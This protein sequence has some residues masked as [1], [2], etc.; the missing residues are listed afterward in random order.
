MRHVLNINEIN[1]KEE[2]SMS[3]VEEISKEAKEVELTKN[4][5]SRIINEQ[6]KQGKLGNEITI[7]ME[8]VIN[9]VG[10]SALYKCQVLNSSGYFNEMIN[11]WTGENWNLSFYYE[12]GAYKEGDVLV[13]RYGLQTKKKN[14]HELIY[15]FP[16]NLKKVPVLVELVD[17]HGEKFIEFLKEKFN[18]E[19]VLLGEIYERW[20]KTVEND[21]NEQEQTKEQ[22]FNEIKTLNRDLLEKKTTLKDIKSEI[23]LEKHK[24]NN[25]EKQIYEIRKSLGFIDDK[26]IQDFSEDFYQLSEEEDFFRI[27]QLLL[28]HH[29]GENL[30]YEYDIIKRFITALRTDQLVLLTGPSGT[31]KSSL[32]EQIGEVLYPCKIHHISVQSNWTD[33]QDLLGFFNPLKNTYLPTPFL[34]ALVDARNDKNTLHIICLDEMNLA[35][36][37]YYFSSLL[38]AR[39]KQ[40]EKRFLD[41]YAYKFYKEAVMDLEEIMQKSF[42]DIQAADIEK[43]EPHIRREARNKYELIYDYPAH[44]SIPTNIRF[45]GTLNMDETV[46]NLSPKVVDRSFIIELDHPNK[47]NEV[48]QEL[49]NQP[50]S[51]RLKINVNEFIL[52]AIEEPSLSVEQQFVIN[53]VLSYSKIL[54]DI[55]NA[56]MNSR[57]IKHMERYVSCLP[58]TKG[59]VDEL[60]SSKILPRILFSKNETKMQN[61]FDAFVNKLPENGKSKIKAEKMKSGKRVVQFW[62]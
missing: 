25:I 10:N 57:G 20:L 42:D 16:N 58:A 55:P 21:I 49:A 48:R 5:V 30:V 52:P 33:V 38:S 56:V 39:E 3:I 22:V 54:E 32:V 24:K 61:A 26:F 37:E 40:P 8:R 60:I 2:L 29:K 34:Q 41:L 36:V 11:P 47:L 4:L 51:G 13:G 6:K 1:L 59:T 27:I 23:E 28:Y 45:V 46:K 50:V 43:L 12:K 17:R 31:G 53:H 62:R 9:Q 7:R 18:G 14:L 44:F 15:P 35:H 19:E